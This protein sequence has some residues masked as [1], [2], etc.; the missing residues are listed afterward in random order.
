MIKFFPGRL[1]GMIWEA[2]GKGVLLLRVPGR[3][4]KHV[5]KIIPTLDF[6]TTCLYEVDRPFPNMASV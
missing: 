3:I 5:I 4:P 1:M 2:Y 6:L